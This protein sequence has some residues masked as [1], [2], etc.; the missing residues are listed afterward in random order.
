MDFREPELIAAFNNGNASYPNQ[1][2]LYPEYPGEL[3]DAWLAG[4]NEAKYYAEQ[5][6]TGIAIGTDTFLWLYKT[7]D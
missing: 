3:E 1:R 6:L 5:E 2:I 7:G 4:Y